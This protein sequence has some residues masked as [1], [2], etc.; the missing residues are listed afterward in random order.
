[1]KAAIIAGCVVLSVSFGASGAHAQNQYPMTI[2]ERFLPPK[3]FDHR[4]TGT[5]TIFKD[6]KQ[7]NIPRE[8]PG[9]KPFACARA[10]HF[11]PN[12]CANTIVEKDEIEKLGWN[13]DIVM[14][15]EIGHCNGWHHDKK[16]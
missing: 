8:C 14:R 15:H 13:Y 16:D 12:T 6:M 9:Y 7:E 1:M 2:Q 11:G 4:Y 10:N 3:E 5:L